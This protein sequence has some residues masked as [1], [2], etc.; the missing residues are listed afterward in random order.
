MTND[1]VK[2]CELDGHIQASRP[3]GEGELRR[4]GIHIFDAALWTDAKNWSMDAVFALAIRY[5][6]SFSAYDLVEKSLADMNRLEKLDPATRSAYALALEGLFRNVRRGDVITALLVPGEG[7]TFFYNGAPTGVAEIGLAC[8]FLDIWF[9]AKTTQPG[10]R[11][12]LLQLAET[13]TSPP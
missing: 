4:L 11:T 9:S 8:R 12:A 7:A 5:G 10:L 3:Y 6:R 13:G 1:F 2:P